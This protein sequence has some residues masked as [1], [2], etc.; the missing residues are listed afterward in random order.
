MVDESSKKRAKLAF[1]EGLEELCSQIDKDYQEII[2]SEGS[3]EQIQILEKAKK[4]RLNHEARM[5]SLENDLFIPYKLTDID[6]SRIRQQTL[7]FS[8]S[9]RGIIN[10]IFALN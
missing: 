4:Y 2:K 3:L 9:S 1:I 6:I 8:F 5:N 7:F 10:I